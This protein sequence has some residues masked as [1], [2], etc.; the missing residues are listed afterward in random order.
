[1]STKFALFELFVYGFGDVVVSEG[2]EFGEVFVCAAATNV[3]CVYDVLCVWAEGAGC[4]PVSVVGVPWAVDGG[5][6]AVDVFEEGGSFVW[7]VCAP[8]V[9]LLEYV[10]PFLDVGGDVG[11]SAFN[12]EEALECFRVQGVCLGY[13]CFFA[14]TFYVFGAADGVVGVRVC[15]GLAGVVFVLRGDVCVCRR[16]LGACGVEERVFGGGVG[17]EVSGGFGA[18]VCYFVAFDACVCF[19]FL[20]CERGVCCFAGNFEGFRYELA[21]RVVFEEVGYCF[22]CL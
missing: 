7:L 8:Y 6:N 16:A 18:F 10:W 21:V 19:Y 1:V 13:M 11:E 12:L 2:A 20:E 17:V 5:D 15:C 4:L 3:F 14:V 9:C 22:P